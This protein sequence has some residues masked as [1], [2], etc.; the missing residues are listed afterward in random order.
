VALR[1]SHR[2]LRVGDFRTLEASGPVVAYQRHT[3]RAADAVL[4]LVNPTLRAVDTTVLVTDAKLMDGGNLVD[5]L[6]GVT[7]QLQGAT[8]MARIPAQTAWVLAPRVVTEGG[9]SNFKRVQ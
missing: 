3:D 7:V 1:K 8:I 4:V 6:G 5:Q 9:Y 2:A